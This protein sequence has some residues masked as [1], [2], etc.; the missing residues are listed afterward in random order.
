MKAKPIKKLAPVALLVDLPE[1]KL[2]AGQVGTVVEELASGVYEV[3]FIDIQG[4]TLAVSEVEATH[5]LPLV[6]ESAVA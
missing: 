6:H 5:L 1:D 2:V 4:N 3:E